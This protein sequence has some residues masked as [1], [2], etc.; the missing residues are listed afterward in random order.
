M[1]HFEYEKAPNNCSR[2]FRILTRKKVAGTTSGPVSSGVL[3][4]LGKWAPDKIVKFT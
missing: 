2:L 3:F 1:L 4:G